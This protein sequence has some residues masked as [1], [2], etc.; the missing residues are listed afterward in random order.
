MDA[1][2]RPRRNHRSTDSVGRRRFGLQPIASRRP[3]G[4]RGA[5]LE[6]QCARRDGEG[7]GA[8]RFGAGGS[9]DGGVLAWHG[10]MGHAM[11]DGAARG[12]ADGAARVG[13]HGH[14]EELWP[15]PITSVND[16]ARTPVPTPDSPPLSLPQLTSTAR[17]QPDL[18]VSTGT[19]KPRSVGMAAVCLAG[20]RPGG[21]V[22]PPERHRPGQPG[23]GTH[24]HAPCYKSP[25][26][27]QWG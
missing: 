5:P 20:R 1:S 21:S 24:L 12:R 3:A 19:C 14:T 25:K 11:A 22:R 10:R 26:Q 7:G 23:Y 4:R 17:R 16:R 18:K 27:G 15:R 8:A 2:R 13:L 6:V 9:R